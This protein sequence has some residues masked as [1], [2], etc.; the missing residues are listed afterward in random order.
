[1]VCTSKL[2]I[3]VNSNHTI[4]HSNDYTHTTSSPAKSNVFFILIVLVSVELVLKSWYDEKIW[5]EEEE[6]G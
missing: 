1:M 5:Q 4:N 6:D 3:K 2:L